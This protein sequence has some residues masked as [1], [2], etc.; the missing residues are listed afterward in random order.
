MLIFAKFCKWLFYSN[1]RNHNIIDHA[2]SYTHPL[3]AKFKNTVHHDQ[4]IP[5]I[6]QSLQLLQKSLTSPIPP[7]SRFRLWVMSKERKFNER[8]TSVLNIYRV[9]WESFFGNFLKCLG[10]FILQTGNEKISKKFSFGAMR[11]K[12]TSELG[13]YKKKS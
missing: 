2:C 11:W 5:T 6:F 13:E 12:C 7:C 9:R 4:P 1:I 10:I 8:W 3:S